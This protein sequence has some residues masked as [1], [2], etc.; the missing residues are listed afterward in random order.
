[1]TNSLFLPNII[2]SCFGKKWQIRYSS[3]MANMLFFKKMTNLWQ[4]I[5]KNG[6]SEFFFD[7]KMRIS[8]FVTIVECCYL[9]TWHKT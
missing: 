3:K 8:F 6:K 9:G 4:K 7:K 5:G 2:V 1:M